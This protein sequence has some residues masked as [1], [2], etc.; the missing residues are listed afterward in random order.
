MA[1]GTAYLDAVKK[2]IRSLQEQA[3][4]AESRIQRLQEELESERAARQS[5]SYDNDLSALAGPTAAFSHQIKSKVEN[6]KKNHSKF[7]YTTFSSLESYNAV[8][9][10]VLPLNGWWCFLTGGVLLSLNNALL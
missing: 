2:K 7:V 3:D 6:D 8:I 5:V 4:N 1:A 10:C 9:D